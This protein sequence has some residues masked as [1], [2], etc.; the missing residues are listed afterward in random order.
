MSIP[1]RWYSSKARRLLFVV[2]NHSRTQPASIAASRT[3]SRSARPTPRP[4]RRLRIVTT[5]HSSPRIAYETSPARCPFKNAIKPGSRV[6][7]TSLP[8]RATTAGSP[9]LLASTWT[10]QARSRTVS[11]WT[12]IMDPSSLRGGA[13]LWTKILDTRRVTLRT[14]RAA[15]ASHFRDSYALRCEQCEAPAWI[16]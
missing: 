8:W 9:Q 4:S 2:I 13:R 6:G 11:G 1:Q 3:A 12:S 15:S 10:A 16:C 7:S 5:S 14:T